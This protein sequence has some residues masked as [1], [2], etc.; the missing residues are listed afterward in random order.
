MYLCLRGERASEPELRTL[1]GG[2]NRLGVGVSPA[3]DTGRDGGDEVLVG[4]V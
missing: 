2:E 1:L 4:V 3:V